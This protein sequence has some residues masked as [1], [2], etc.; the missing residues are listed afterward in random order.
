[1]ISIKALRANQS[2]APNPAETYRETEAEPARSKVPALLALALGAVALFLKSLF[3]SPAASPTGAASPAAEDA[4]ARGDLAQDSTAPAEQADEDETPEKPHQRGSGNPVGSSE[5]AAG[6]GDFLAV[7]SPTFDFDRLPHQPVPPAAVVFS[8]P[9]MPPGN[10]NGASPPRIHSAGEGGGGSAPPTVDTPVRSVPKADDEDGERAEDDGDGEV[11]PPVNRRPQ[12]NGPLRLVDIDRCH[13]AAILL[14]SLLSGATDPDGDPLSV[15]DLTATSGTLTMAEGG[16]RFGSAPDD[17]EFVTLSY[18]VSDG[19]SEVRQTASFGFLDAPDIVG[20]QADDLLLG[21]ECADVIDARGGDD[22]VDARGG[23]DLVKGGSGADHIVA[24]AGDD[25]VLAG[26]GDD[27]VFGGAG[28]DLIYGGAGNDRLFGGDGHDALFGQAGND[29][30]EGGAGDDRLDGGDGD[31][32]V[33]GDAGDDVIAAGAGHDVVSGG[34]GD[35]VIDGGEGDDAIDAGAGRNVVTTGDGRNEVRAGDG[36]SIIFGGSG[37]DLA[38]TG[39]GADVVRLGAGADSAAAGAGADHVFGEDG[40]DQLRG[41]SGNDV[42]EGGADDDVLDGGEGADS[43]SADAG[44][45]TVLVTLDDANDVYAGGDGTDELDASASLL[46]VTF[47]QIQQL[48]FGAEIGRDAMAGFEALIGGKGDDI[49]IIV[50]AETLLFGGQGDDVFTFFD[51][52]DSDDRDHVRQILD[53]EIGDRIVIRPY[54]FSDDPKDGKS[55]DDDAFLKAYADA[56]DREPYVRFQRQ[57]SDDEE[58]EN[59]DQR[60][61]DIADA[62]IVI[63]A[64]IDPKNTVH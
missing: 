54:A 27:I 30:L 5:L 8:P 47:D 3:P 9:P 26:D 53:Y 7:N 25:T 17:V 41:E 29:R 62:P 43:V 11:R 51:L 24:G 61:D 20:T 13:G 38:I 35:D 16:W 60:I 49:F 6:V 18:G 19:Q 55:K 58:H 21:T 40:A 56:E 31:D 39:A 4:V 59:D 46:G 23:N 64:L 22:N 44:D 36:G 28:A 57:R 32:T 63:S 52:D 33:L 34:E 50:D 2:K 14:A 37:V 1:M 15:V 42:L 12:I 45:D 10:D 48:V